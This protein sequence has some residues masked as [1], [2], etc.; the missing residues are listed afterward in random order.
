MIPACRRCKHYRVEFG[1]C[2]Q[3][4]GHS[5]LISGHV[6]T[7]NKDAKDMRFSEAYCGSRGVW[8]EAKDSVPEG[9]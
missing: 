4:R 6:F 8:F 3:S 7:N 1:S 2:Q 9:D 5:D